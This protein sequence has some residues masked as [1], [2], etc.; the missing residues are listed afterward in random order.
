[1]HFF[2]SRFPT[3]TG[4]ELTNSIIPIAYKHVFRDA[5]LPTLLFLHGGPGDH[6]GYLMEA[7]G[8]EVEAEYNVIWMDQRGCGNS[9]RDLKSTDFTIARFV[10]DI[11]LVLDTIGIGKVV[12][13]AHSFGVLLGGLFCALHND[14]VAAYISICGVGSFLHYQ[15]RLFHNLKITFSNSPQK[16]Q[17][18]AEVE[19]QRNGFFKLIRCFRFAREAKAHYKNYDV[20]KKEIIKYLEQCVVH[21]EYTNDT[22]TESEEALLSLCKYDSLASFEIYHALEDIQ[23]P[24]LCI[25]GAHD[26]ANDQECVRTYASLIKNSSFKLFTNSGHHPFQEEKEEFLQT[27]RDFLASQQLM[28]KEDSCSNY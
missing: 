4:W 8:R 5:S 14:R 9:P 23:A 22:V 19:K 11:V 3:K 2:Q 26:K 12:I 15:E 24:T 27:L 25:A 7:F 13:V 1:M 18:I 17:E 10:E 20:T 21:G 28:M 16:L 6:S